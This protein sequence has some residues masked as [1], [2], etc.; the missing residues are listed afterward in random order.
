MAVMLRFPF[1]AEKFPHA[2]SYLLTKAGPSTRLRIMK[3]VYLAD[4][5]H[6]V[7][8][9]RPIVG[10][11]YV[12]LGQGPVASLA[13]DILEDLE[14]IK[15]EEQGLQVDGPFVKDLERMVDVDLVEPYPQ[16]RAKAEPDCARLSKTDREVSSTRS[17]SG[18]A[19]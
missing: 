1:D 7:R 4:R 10:G 13:L 16:Y 14:A 19:A 17:S 3:L 2:L 9:G 18:S 8:H 5:I 12:A 6:L 11:R 15:G